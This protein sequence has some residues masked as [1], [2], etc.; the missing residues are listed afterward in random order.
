MG[1]HGERSQI[2]EYMCPLYPKFTENGHIDNV[3][4]TVKSMFPKERSKSKS[5]CSTELCK[6]LKKY[7]VKRS[8]EKSKQTN[9]SSDFT[10][11]I[12]FLSHPLLIVRRY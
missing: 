2:Q 11:T 5:L 10:M 6:I 9:K 1:K 7:V 3:Y 8:K 4:V 12:Y